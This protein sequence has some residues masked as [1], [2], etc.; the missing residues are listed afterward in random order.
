MKKYYTPI[1]GLYYIFKDVGDPPD[2]F[3]PDYFLALLCQSVYV[4]FILVI[5]QIFMQQ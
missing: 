1:F 3:S 4:V 5:L 2:P